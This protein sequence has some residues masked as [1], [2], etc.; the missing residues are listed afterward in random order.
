[1]IPNLNDCE[2]HVNFVT[3][4]K[5]E[6]L[7]LPWKNTKVQET[8]HFFNEQ[9]E[10]DILSLRGMFSISLFPPKRKK[11]KLLSYAAAFFIIC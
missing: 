7:F 3:K 8:L 11:E 9:Q 2:F 1:M 4:K 5:L 6:G 10:E